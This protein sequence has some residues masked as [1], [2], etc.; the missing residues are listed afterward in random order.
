MSEATCSACGQQASIKSL[1]DLNGQTYCAPCVQTA[2]DNAKRSGQPTAYMPLINR[3]ICARCNSYISDQSTAMQTGGARFCGVCAPL[4]KDWGYPAWLR[5]GLAA[6]LLLLIVALVHGK[7]YFHAGRA[8]YIGEH[9]VEQG[10]HAEALPYLKETLSIAPGSDKAALLAAKAALLTGDVATADKALHGHDDGHFEDGQSAEFLE[11]NSLWDR[12]NQ[13][14]EKADKASELAEKDGNS[15]EAARLMHEAASSYP[16]LPG[17]RIAAENLDAGAAFDRG[18]FDTYLSISEN[19]WKQQA[20][21]GSAIALAN[22]LACKYVV[23]GIIPLRERAME[24]IAKS[25]ELAGGDAKTLKSLDDY[26]PLITYRI[27]SRQIISKQEYN[28]K[29]RTGKNPIK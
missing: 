14:L 19:Q 24:M 15:A 10:K 27:E 21:A 12:A 6:L 29:F 13:A 11:V 17:L 4:I 20:G 16:E 9:L 18:D 23:T 3:S 2:V 26:I 1:F 5:V 25:K 8:M 28:R 7:K 22:A